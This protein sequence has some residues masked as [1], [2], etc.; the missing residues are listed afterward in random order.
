M[1]GIAQKFKGPQK[2]TQ[3]PLMEL[4]YW[5]TCWIC[6]GD[7]PKKECPKKGQ[8]Q[9]NLHGIVIIATRM[10]TMNAIAFSCIQSCDWVNS[11]PLTPSKG[12]MGPK[13]P[14]EKVF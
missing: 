11:N 6:G 13:T 2:Q 7:H 1:K 8:W 9:G 10:V 3:M 12:T 4:S 14:K 5:V